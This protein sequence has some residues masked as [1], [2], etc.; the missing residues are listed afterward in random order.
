M[1]SGVNVIVASAIATSRVK[2]LTFL[3]EIGV[4]WI[5]HMSPIARGK[6]SAR[7]RYYPCQI[8]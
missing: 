4:F 5:V 2:T 8:W 3:L 1:Y 6:A 7:L